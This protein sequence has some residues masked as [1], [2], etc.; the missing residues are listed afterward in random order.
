[1]GFLYIL[2]VPVLLGFTLIGMVFAPLIALTADANGNLPRYLKWFQTFDATLD[3]GRQPQYGFTGSDWWVRTRWL[4]R[5][6][7]YGFAY[8]PLSQPFFP[9][10]WRFWF[11]RSK[12]HP[13]NM[14]FL[15]LGPRLAFDCHYRLGPFSAKLGWAAWNLFDE[16]NLAWKTTPWGPLWRVPMKFTL[17]KWTIAIL[18]G[19]K[20]AVSVM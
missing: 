11:H 5:N 16:A 18:I 20:I 2:L 12:A 13:D 14:L 7:S 3:E 1:M 10:N 15:A 19:M 6:P 8:G 17:D 4:W 9:A